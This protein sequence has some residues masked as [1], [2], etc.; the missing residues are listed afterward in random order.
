MKQKP[1]KKCK[2]IGRVRPPKGAEYRVFDILITPASKDGWIT[3][4]TC[5][6]KGIISR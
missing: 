1:C 5:Y 3:C 2:G 4:K 6:G